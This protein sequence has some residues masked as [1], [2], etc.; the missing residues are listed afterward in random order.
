MV[1]RA[2]SRPAQWQFWLTGLYWALCDLALLAS[3]S[4]TNPAVGGPL[5]TW[6]NVVTLAGGL[7]A[8]GTLWQQW[9]DTRQKL[10]T[11]A[12]HLEELRHDHLP[13]TYVRQDIF[14]QLE[15]RMR[16]VEQRRGGR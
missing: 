12:Q 7:I 9:K 13:Q 1:Y 2:L 11:V 16:L 6:Q 4:P 14:A 10:D 5:I 8:V 3:E 15:E